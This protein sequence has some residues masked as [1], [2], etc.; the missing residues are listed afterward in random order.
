[1]TNMGFTSNVNFMLVLGN[2]KTK[3]INVIPQTKSIDYYARNK[4]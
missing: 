4:S 3:R 2:T 1:M